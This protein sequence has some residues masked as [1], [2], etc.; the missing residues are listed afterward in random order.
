MVVVSI[1]DDTRIYNIS[2]AIEKYILYIIIMIVLI[3][4]LLLL[5]LAY[6]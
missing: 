6:C 4:L 2:A 3:L 1:E 5:L